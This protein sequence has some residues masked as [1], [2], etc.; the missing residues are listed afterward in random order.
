MIISS[1]DDVMLRLLSNLFGNEDQKLIKDF[2]IKVQMLDDIKA[3]KDEAEAK[4]R[5]A[6]K[7][8]YPDLG[9]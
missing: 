4:V 9:L 6:Y 5:Q 2:D 7:E 1:R 3:A 8:T